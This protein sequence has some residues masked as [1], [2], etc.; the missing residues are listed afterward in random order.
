MKIVACVRTL[1]EEASILRFIKS[2]ISWV[3]AILVA[4]GGS[5]DKTV[6]IAESMPLV[7]VRPF[8]YYINGENGYFRNPQNKHI[9]FLLDWAAEENADWI[10]FD[11]CDCFPNWMLQQSARHI[12]ESTD[13]KAI[14]AYRMYI[15]G[16]DK[17]FPRLNEPGQSIWAWRTGVCRAIETS[18]DDEE[19]HMRIPYPPKEVSLFLD[20]PL[21]LLH[22]AYPNEKVVGQKLSFYR[23]SGQVPTMQHPKRFGGELEDLPAWASETPLSSEPD[24]A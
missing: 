12:M 7:K 19:W 3:D 24:D 23:G 18:T 16:E 9:N 8:H 17:W 14:M 4:D 5:Q 13:K 1:N 6:E 11:D 2:Y 20:W 21:A 15:Y 10:I 22:R